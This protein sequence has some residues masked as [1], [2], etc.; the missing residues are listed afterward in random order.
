LDSTFY[1]ANSVLFGPAF[2]ASILLGLLLSVSA[3]ALGYTGAR[4]R[5]ASARGARAISIFNIMVW[6]FTGVYIFM[7]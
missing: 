6:V 5:V 3:M 1:I 4:K 2:A 7:S